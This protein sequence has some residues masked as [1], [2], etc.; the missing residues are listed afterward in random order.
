VRI[1]EITALLRQTITLIEGKT[2]A[3]ILE[4]KKQSCQKMAFKSMEHQSKRNRTH[5]HKQ[6][7][8]AGTA[9]HVTRGITVSYSR[10]KE[11]PQKFSKSNQPKQKFV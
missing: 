1:S 2:S 5:N 7:R 9:P 4:Q 8:F 3:E 6:K 10:R 11:R